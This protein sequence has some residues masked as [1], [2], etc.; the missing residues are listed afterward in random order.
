MRI[1]PESPSQFIQSKSKENFKIHSNSNANRTNEI[2]PAVNVQIRKIDNLKVSNNN[3]SDPTIATKVLDGLD[4]GMI[5]FSQTQ[6]DAI[7]KV[8]A[9][10]ADVVDAKSKE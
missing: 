6:R 1:S 3:P 10:R 8:L 2:A 9:S 7:A 5:D 4:S